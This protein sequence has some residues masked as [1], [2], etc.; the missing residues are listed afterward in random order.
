MNAELLRIVD[1]IAKDKSIE[2]EAVFLDIEQAIAS[3]LR[4]Q[5]NVEDAAEF[6]VAVARD[7]GDP[8][9]ALRGVS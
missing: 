6:Q 4:R 5:Y 9:V 1:N 8:A 2:K 3:G 7:S